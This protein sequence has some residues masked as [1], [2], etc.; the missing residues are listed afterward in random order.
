MSH[1]VAI[2]TRNN[3][4]LSQLVHRELRKRFTHIDGVR[5]ELSDRRDEREAAAL[6]RHLARKAG[7]CS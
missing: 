2:L 3:D 5:L 1:A 6:A 4:K 7:A